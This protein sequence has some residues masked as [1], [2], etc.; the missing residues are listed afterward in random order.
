MGEIPKVSLLLCNDVPADKDIKSNSF[1]TK[2][3]RKR[4]YS[5]IDFKGEINPDCSC[6]Q[7]R[8]HSSDKDFSSSTQL[9]RGLSKCLNAA[10]CS[11]F[12]KK[13]IQGAQRRHNAIS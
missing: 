6:R 11:T 5:R 4:T 2:L 10:T 8:R 9:R 12:I 1:N 7:K 13:S 3:L